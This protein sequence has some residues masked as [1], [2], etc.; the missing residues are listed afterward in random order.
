[1]AIIIRGDIVWCDFNPVVGSE[2][3]G[4]RP[5]V[6]V[7]TDRANRSSPCTIVVPFTTR[8][9]RSLFP[10]HVFVP[11]GEGGLTQDSIALCEQ[12]RVI[13]QRRIT[14]VVGHLGESRLDELGGALRAALEL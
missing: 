9:R 13:D 3:A 11:A 12:V 10:S 7:Q 1:M 14:R 8:I 2:Q 4:I 5:A 6:V